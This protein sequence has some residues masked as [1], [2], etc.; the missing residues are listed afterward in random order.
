MKKAVL[1]P[2]VGFSL[3]RLDD[4]FQ[5]SLQECVKNLNDALFYYHLPFFPQTGVEPALIITSATTDSMLFVS[6]IQSFA[7]TTHFEIMPKAEAFRYLTRVCPE[8]FN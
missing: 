5:S 3:T 4:S 1:K 7:Q 6:V 2:P 8:N